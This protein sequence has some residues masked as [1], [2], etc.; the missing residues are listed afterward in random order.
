[1]RRTRTRLPG[2][3]P[4]QLAAQPFFSVSGRPTPLLIGQRIKRPAILI[5]FAHLLQA[6]GDLPAAP[7]HT[8]VPQ[9]D[10]AVHSQARDAN[11]ERPVHPAAEDRV[12]F[13]ALGP[14]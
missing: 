13:W 8:L 12:H 9:L 10:L 7:Q 2:R 3:E 11:E 4:E 5:T 6:L 1:V 14:P